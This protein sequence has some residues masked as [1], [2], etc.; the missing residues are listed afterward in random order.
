VPEC[1]WICKGRCVNDYA[2]ADAEEHSDQPLDAAL[3]QASYCGMEVAFADGS[4]YSV[5]IRVRAV[6][7]GVVLGMGTP[8]L[9]R[10][11]SHSDCVHSSAAF[12]ASA[13]VSR[14]DGR[15]C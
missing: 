9:A 3:N 7:R 2:A 4:G 5:R 12:R 13:W 14:A 8:S 11:N 10:P 15:S 1:V 6:T